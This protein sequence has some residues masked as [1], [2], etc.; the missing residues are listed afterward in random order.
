MSPL[1]IYGIKGPLERELIILF[2]DIYIIHT[3]ENPSRK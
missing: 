3:S 1:D 2:Q